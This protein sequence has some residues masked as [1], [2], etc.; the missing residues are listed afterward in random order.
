MSRISGR[1]LLDDEGADKASFTDLKEPTGSEA[2]QEKAT[3]SE[4][5]DCC[6]DAP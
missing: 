3:Q 2:P 5:L 6:F 4:L 1:N